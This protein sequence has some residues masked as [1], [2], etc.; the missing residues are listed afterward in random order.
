[1][2]AYVI[3]IMVKTPKD[4]LPK[5]KNIRNTREKVMMLVGGDIQVYAKDRPTTGVVVLAG[6]LGVDGVLV[7]AH[8]DDGYWGGLQVQEQKNIMSW[9]IANAHKRFL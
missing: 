5:I 6:P 7:F 4:L 8:L 1:M 3:T 9:F 2:S